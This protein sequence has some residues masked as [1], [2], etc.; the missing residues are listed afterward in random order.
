LLEINVSLRFGLHPEE[1]ATLDAMDAMQALWVADER[2]RLA[3]A[4]RA[5]LSGRISG[6]TDWRAERHELGLQFVKKPKF[7]GE[8]FKTQVPA[9]ALMDY[10]VIQRPHNNFKDVEIF[11]DARLSNG[12][13]VLTSGSSQTAAAFYPS[14]I[15]QNQTFRCQVTFRLTAPPGSGQADGMAVVFSPEKKLGLRGYGLG[16]SG[17]GGKGD[18]AVES[19]SVLLPVR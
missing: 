7:R 18:F 13:I 1:R 5:E 12:Q 2:G 8:T 6:P 9:S 4:E 16:Y 3:E 10:A 14:A 15:R 17:L 19:G 11:S